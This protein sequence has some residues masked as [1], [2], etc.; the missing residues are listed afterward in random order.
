MK[1]RTH[2]TALP[3]FLF[4][5]G[6]AVTLLAEPSGPKQVYHE[7]PDSESEAQHSKLVRL[8]GIDFKTFTLLCS[9]IRED[10]RLPLLQIILDSQIDVEPADCNVC[11]PL[12]RRLASLCKSISEPKVPGK[13]GKGKTKK[14]KSKNQTELNAENAGEE[15][16]TPSPSP[17]PIVKQ[18][19]PHT[20]VI[21]LTSSFFT[22]L[23]GLKNAD[24]FLPFAQRFV[25]L[26]RSDYSRTPGEQRYFGMVAEY[27]I[28]PFKGIAQ[29]V[30][31]QR[32]EEGEEE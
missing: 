14:S 18:G 29:S 25:R 9:A 31:R 30:E 8:T 4:F 20:K 23:S 19:E 22:G 27:A 11:K 1:L 13:S 21:Q 12:F 32:A 17:S 15:A 10:G 2:L 26:L 28:A 6:F 7:D 5:W 24:T 16:N 3:I